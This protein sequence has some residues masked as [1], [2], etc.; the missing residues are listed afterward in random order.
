[1]ICFN[2]YIPE[3]KD[4]FLMETTFDKIFIDFGGQNQLPICLAVAISIS[5]ALTNS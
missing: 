3:K 5:K 1:M 2:S 4:I